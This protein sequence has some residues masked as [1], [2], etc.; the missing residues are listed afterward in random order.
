MS[1]FLQKPGTPGGGAVETLDNG[2]TLDGTEGISRRNS[3]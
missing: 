2:L 3:Y 1:G